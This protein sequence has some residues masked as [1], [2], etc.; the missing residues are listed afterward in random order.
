MNIQVYFKFKNLKGEF[1]QFI[2][3]YVLRHLQKAET[4]STFDLPVYKTTDMLNVYPLRTT[5]RLLN[6]SIVSKVFTYTFINQFYKFTQALYT[7]YIMVQLKILLY[8]FYCLI[9]VKCRN[10]YGIF[11]MTVCFF[12]G[13]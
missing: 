8:S 1:I 7:I 6:D 12:V 3:C 5:L 10:Y 9:I 11:S 13:F 4:Y 2:K